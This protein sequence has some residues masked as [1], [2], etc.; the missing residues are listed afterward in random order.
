MTIEISEAGSRRNNEDGKHNGCGQE[1]QTRRANR[2]SAM[3]DAAVLNG[4]FP[5][6]N[7]PKRLT[8]VWPNPLDGGERVT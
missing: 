1:R 7:L 3:K 5:S 2:A 6:S 8:A 4:C